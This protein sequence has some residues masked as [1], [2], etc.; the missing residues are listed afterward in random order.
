MLPVILV[1]LFVILLSSGLTVWHIRSWEAAREE[2]LDKPEREY[3]WDQ[4]RRRVKASTLLALV[5]V[6]M[7]GSTLISNQVAL[8]FFWVGVICLL[9]WIVLI[10]ILDVAAT[11]RY[12]SAMRRDHKTQRAEL[13]AEIHRLQ[14]RESNGHAS[15]G[16][17]PLE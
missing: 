8:A 16:E 9:L 5:G 14:R 6:A 11:R 3:R 15:V 4:F 12:F 1:S 17:G 13:E 2:D 10:A 7:M